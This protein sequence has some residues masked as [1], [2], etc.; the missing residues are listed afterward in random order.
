MFQ[1]ERNSVKKEML[2]E[3]YFEEQKQ[4]FL[5]RAALLTN[6]F[7]RSF[8]EHC[9]ES[10][11]ADAFEIFLETKTR[12]NYF[13]KHFSELD[14]EAAKRFFKLI[15]MYHSIKTCRKRRRELKWTEM[16][17]ALFAVYHFNDVEKKLTERL[18]QC[19]CTMDG[20]FMDMFA[21]TF[22]R[23]LFLS[24][25]ITPFSLAFIENFCYNSYSN[26]MASFTRYLSINLR[27]KRA[28]NL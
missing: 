22:A 9:T 16:R 20:L 27:L 13:H 18:Y 11:V 25:T 8:F 5:E 3:K 10:A 2:I 28:A 12:D 26:F 14:E 17:D 19:A 1:F 23:Y 21:K 7:Y 24:T 4:P 6:S 15:A